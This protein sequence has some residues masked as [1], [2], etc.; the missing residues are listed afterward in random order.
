ME[1]QIRA[2]KLHLQTCS[3][4]KGKLVLIQN[5]DFYSK[6]LEPLYLTFLADRASG[7]RNIGIGAI[8]AYV[9]AFG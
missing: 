5:F 1:S 9:K 4:F 8:Q 7:V 6:N 3:N 2:Y